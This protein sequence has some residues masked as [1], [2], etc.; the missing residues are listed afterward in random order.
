L[1]D[2][3]DELR[4]Q[5]SA[6]GTNGLLSLSLETKRDTLPEALALVKEILRNPKFESSELEVIQRQAIT[7]TE[8]QMTEP[9][10][11]A[12]RATRRALTPYEP[13]DIRYV[14]TLKEQVERYRSVNVE[15]LQSLHDKMMNG[16]HGEVTVVGD[17]DPAEV[18]AIFEDMFQGWK[19]TV[20]FERIAQPAQLDVPGKL[21]EIITPDKANAVYYGGLQMAM[22]DSDP[23]YSA[24]LIGN[25]ILGGGA[26]S[27]R[28]GD[29]V[30]QNEG[31]SYTVGSGVNAHPIDERGN[32]TLFAI[33]NPK[34]RDRLV[35]VIN[36]EIERLLEGG[37]TQAEL[38]AAKQ[39][40]LQSE[41]LSR[42]QD[43]ALASILGSTLFVGRD[44]Q[45]YANLEENIQNLTVEAV[46]T[47]LRKYIDPKRLVIFTAGDFR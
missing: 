8:S 19:S 30:R 47:A 24:L 21:S 42:T 6:S 7:G 1:Q 32:L 34:N 33:T 39:G 28:L 4:C 17:F 35:S 16:Q 13:S 44:M 23:D 46:N 12:G 18:E 36:E 11:L 41:Q 10:V 15:Q 2:K 40:S 22:R 27:S 25:Y 45:Y 26:L 14:P 9:T 43:S 38:D 31:L 29:R 37:I 3:L 5:L 20:R